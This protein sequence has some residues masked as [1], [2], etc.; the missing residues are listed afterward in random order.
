MLV[1]VVEVN[2]PVCCL[3]G[4]TLVNIS[5][6]RIP[7]TGRLRPAFETEIERWDLFWLPSLH[8]VLFKDVKIGSLDSVEAEREYLLRFL[9]HEKATNRVEFPG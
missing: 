3:G 8:G 2:A 1:A 9:D 7:F 5:T 6:V 4:E